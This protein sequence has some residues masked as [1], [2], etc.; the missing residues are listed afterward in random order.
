MTPVFETLERIAASA[1][2][3]HQPLQ[4]SNM[5][6]WQTQNQPT[7]WGWL[8]QPIYGDLGDSFSDLPHYCIFFRVPRTQAQQRHCQAFLRDISAKNF[9]IAAC[10]A[11]MTDQGC[12]WCQVSHMSHSHHLEL[13]ILLA[14][15]IDLTCWAYEVTLSEDWLAQTVGLRGE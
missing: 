10:P 13:N 1:K 7:I 14:V 15:W 9:L 8:I 2:L 6:V 3:P 4:C 11:L 12:S 5:L